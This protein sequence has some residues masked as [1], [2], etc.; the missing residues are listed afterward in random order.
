MFLFC[1]CMSSA[2]HPFSSTPIHCNHLH[3][4]TPHHRT[5]QDGNGSIDKGELREVFET[6]GCEMTD[7]EVDQVFKE[8]D[9]GGK[10]EITLAAFKQWFLA[11][12]ARLRSE[13]RDVFTRI[14]TNKVRGCGSL[15]SSHQ[16]PVI[17]HQSSVISHQTSV[18]SHQSPVISHH[19]SVI[20]H[21][22]SNISY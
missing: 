8:L 19:S 13:V 18:T 3:L 2:L 16:S 22:S 20:S 21:Q 5:P 11:S 9:Q 17:S 1:H 14:D 15:V 7:G 12:D 6:L 4:S 10:G